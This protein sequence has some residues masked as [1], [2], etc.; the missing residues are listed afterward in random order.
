MLVVSLISITIFFLL[1]MLGIAG[2]GFSGWYYLLQ[3][4]EK[5]HGEIILYITIIA[6]CIFLLIWINILFHSFKRIHTIEKMIDLARVNGIVDGERFD[7][8][9]KLGFELKML[10]NEIINISEQ[11]A[12]RLFFM[13]SLS[14]A[15]FEVI[16]EKI[17][18]VDIKGAI[19]YAGQ[20]A[21][22]K[23]D[24][25]PLSEKGLAITELIPDFDFAEAASR[26]TRE[27]SAVTV[28]LHAVTSMVCIPIFGRDNSPNGFL[29]LLDNLEAA[30]FAVEHLFERF[31]SEKKKTTEK[32]D[33]VKKRFFHW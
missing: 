27:H 9:G 19:L 31:R 2:I 7:T 23:K 22:P 1:A 15:V 24:A 28:S 3:F 8:F 29:L 33:L 13:D 20:K 25:F 21:I 17:I 26:A 14:A 30:G 5:Q 6:L 11:R 16:N 10:Y 12:Q 32:R 18:A 4:G